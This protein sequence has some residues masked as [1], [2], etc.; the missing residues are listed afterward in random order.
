M[1]IFHLMV[2]VE[3]SNFTLFA[4]LLRSST[5]NFSLLAASAVPNANP[6]VKPTASTPVTSFFIGFLQMSG[7]LNLPGIDRSD[8]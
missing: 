1:T 8:P 2:S 5:P 3:G 7:D 6:T 4:I